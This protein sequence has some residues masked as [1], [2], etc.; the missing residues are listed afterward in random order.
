MLVDPENPRRS[1][2]SAVPAETVTALDERNTDHLE[3]DAITR[4]TLCDDAG[5][6]PNGIICD[7]INRAHVGQA[8]KAHIRE[9]LAKGKR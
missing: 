7:H 4:C 9:M 5:Y 2:E 1:L 8:Q 6:R 3:P